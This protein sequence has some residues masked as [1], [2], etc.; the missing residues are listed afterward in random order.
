MSNSDQVATLSRRSFLRYVGFGA[1]TVA[2]GDPSGL[3][4]SR[5]ASSATKGVGW[6]QADGTPDWW[7][8][9]YPLPL[10][11]GDMS[12]ADDAKRLSRFE[13]RDALVLPDGFRWEPLAFWGDRF[14]PKEASAKQVQF[15]YAA[16]YTGL[17]PIPGSPSEYW[18][19]VNHEYI[20]A[21]PWLQGWNE[22][23]RDRFG[24]CPVTAD[25][26][27]RG[28]P[29]LGAT[30][31]LVS[32]AGRSGVPD[33]L[34]SDIRRICSAGMSDLGVSVL[35]VRR[36]ADGTF[37][38][39]S[40]A[41]DHLRISGLPEDNRRLIDAGAF[42]FSG[43]ARSLLGTPV[44]TFSNCS[45]EVTPWGTFLTCEENFQDQVPE[46]LAPDGSALPG[47]RKDFGGLGDVGR[48][49]GQKLPFE[50]QGLGT[51]IADPLDGRQYGWV[52][53][54]DPFRRTMVKHTPLG[55]FRHENVALR[56]EPGKKLVAYL[57]DDRRGGHVWKYVS[58]DVVTDVRDPANSRLLT[59][60]TLYVARFNP[61]FTGQWIPLKPQTPVTLPAVDQTADGIAWVPN[62]PAGGQVLV[63][64]P[65]A[66]KAGKAQSTVA[67]WQK[68]VEAFA[69]KAIG[70]MT[71][72]DLV[73][74][75]EKQAVLLMDAYAMANLAGGTPCARPEDIEVHPRDRSVYIAFTDSTG[76]G[77]GSPDA[78][79]FPDSRRKN[80]RQYGAI[81][82]L[83]E[84]KNEATAETFGWGKFVAAGEVAE[85]GG[86]FACADNLVFDAD[87][88]LWMVC[89]ITTPTH[90]YA[91]TRDSK[92][93]S[94]PGDKNFLGVFG[95]NAMFMIPTSGPNAGVPCCFA[96]GPM[97]CELTGPT[98]TPDG[99]TLILAVQHPGELYGTRDQ[100]RE[101]NAQ[102]DR[103][104]KIAAR[105]G[106][107][108]EQHRTVPL[109]S[110]FPSGRP[111]EVPRP[112]VVCIV[113]T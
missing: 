92:D 55:R 75:A 81:Y 50:F 53:E 36:N 3:H 94:G 89:D 76:S 41:D 63:G 43:P 111:G 26:L 82:R 102:E 98:F 68:A 66:V 88:N 106:T 87:A 58:D 84:T 109:G 11:G 110:N 97:E 54:I 83:V 7:P 85:Q 103:T 65:E 40:K 33:A 8:V 42:R 72:G 4:A 104:L 93:K 90:N 10:P 32:P 38:V 73:A 52:C 9:A 37:A 61:D 60:G 22:V 48:E 30:F 107:L 62:R 12:A 23:H 96:T 13:V 39:Q 71:L 29:L 47:D 16:D 56:V 35:R 17:Q 14:G 25:G 34:Q 5:A 99:R 18:L 79:I 46:Y 100:S 31:D 86:G 24:P 20:S 44:G 28:K 6:V 108:F 112:G 21:R 2:L 15:G 70:A 80:S 67:D 101:Q 49:P 57:G 27:L 45:G 78:R 77:D 95:N 64:T 113:R 91:V 19:I 59:E 69:G 105:D 74:G 1:A 51:G